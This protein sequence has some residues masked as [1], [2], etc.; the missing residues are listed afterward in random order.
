ME[1]QGILTR[2]LRFFEQLQ[3][4]CYLCAQRL[5]FSNCSTPRT[6]MDQNTSITVEA[7]SASRQ[8]YFRVKYNCS[9]V[10]RRD[11]H[12]DPAVTTSPQKVFKFWN[13]QLSSRRVAKGDHSPSS[14]PPLKARGAGLENTSVDLNGLTKDDAINA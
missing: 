12:V 1:A 3:L 13:V 14:L 6:Q 7:K 10:A 4:H 9:H 11:R 8:D 2:F 5:I